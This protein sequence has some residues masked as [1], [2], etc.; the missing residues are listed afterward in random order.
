MSSPQVL[1]HHP[2]VG[3]NPSCDQQRTRPDEEPAQDRVSP[4]E[5]AFP[6]L[7]FLIVDPLPNKKCAT[8]PLLRSRVLNPNLPPAMA[9]RPK[10]TIS[11]ATVSGPDCP[12]LR[13]E[14]RAA[15]PLIAFPLGQVASPAR[16][17]PYT[18]PQGSSR[19][20]ASP[21]HRKLA[22]VRR[23]TAPPEIATRVDGC[24]QGSRSGLYLH[25]RLR[26]PA[27]RQRLR[28]SQDGIWEPE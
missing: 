5:P 1:G 24:N 19:Q 28:Y 6:R 23:T 21:T 4:L 12:I 18:V 20:A 14:T 22:M 3:G 9:M 16:W 7:A 11:A 17:A 15:T 27:D 25:E 26:C 8:E 13:G 2:V 10:T